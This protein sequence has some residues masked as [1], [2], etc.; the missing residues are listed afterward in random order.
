MINDYIEVK[1]IS[2]DSYYYN[3]FEYIISLQK[4]EIERQRDMLKEYADNIG[5]T[6]SKIGLVNNS[7]NGSGQSLFEEFLDNNGLY[8]NICGIQFICSLKCEERLPNRSVGWINE[9][10]SYS[11]RTSKFAWHCLLLEHVLFE[12]QGT[13]LKFCKSANGM[14]DVVCDVPRTEVKDFD[15]IAG[16]QKYILQ[17]VQDYKHNLHLPINKIGFIR[18]TN[19]LLKPSKQEALFLGS[20]WDDDT[21]NDRQLLNLQA[22]FR[23]KNCFLI[24][25]PY[26]TSWIEGWFSIND[27]PFIYRLIANFR[28]LMGYYW[29]HLPFHKHNFC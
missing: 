23:R 14:V 20:I 15:K 18:Y 28:Q 21:E 7:L 24:D 16:T 26:N 6:S 3:I 17:F 1:K 12:P 19:M 13:A 4:N 27:I 5:I 29:H 22:K 10:M 9:H 25:M 11:F 2:K 8:H